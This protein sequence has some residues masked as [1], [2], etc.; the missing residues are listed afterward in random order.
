MKRFVRCSAVLT[1]ALVLA[2]S[3]VPAWCQSPQVAAVRERL[4]TR[5]NDPT[6][7]YY[8]SLFEVADSNK[9]GSIEALR[10]V[11]K[12]GKG[13]LP[14]RGV[15]F[16]PV[17]DEP[18]FRE[19]RAAMERKL[20]KVT[21]ARELFRLDKGL[22][23]E[24]ISYD[25]VTRSY[26]VGSIAATRIVRVDSLGKV[27]ELS[28]PGE[29]HQVLGLAADPAR[30]RLHAVSTGALTGS[31]GNQIVSYDLDSGAR[32]RS[33]DVPAAT[34]LNDV[35]VAA[36]GDLYTTDTQ[37]GG[38]YRVRAESGAVD[39]VAAPGTLPGANGVA[40]SA[41]GAALYVAHSTGVARLELGSGAVL[42]R[43]EIPAG[44]TIGAIDGL[45]T[46]GGTLIGIQNTTNPGRV[47]RMRLRPDGKGVERIETLLSHHHPAIDEPTTGVIVGRRFALLAT[48]QVARFTPEGKVTSP[49]TLK[50][51]VVLSIDLDRGSRN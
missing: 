38:I 48:T 51:P 50:P 49:E 26:F 1:L 33:V 23:P 39:T 11:E 24:G 36:N 43:L 18:G 42:P 5:P 15:G 46:D 7:Y 14:P 40:L 44:E 41:D 3:A 28:R 4:K 34:Q 45:Y 32:V 20:P 9:A 29:L 12:L 31:G 6:L 47:I 13:F 25:P 27:S 35:A 37:G 8:L 10:Q 16:D 21:A 19:V 17:W 22:I 2:A 30:R